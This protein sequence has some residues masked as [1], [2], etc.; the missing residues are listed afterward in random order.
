[1]SEIAGEPAHWD[2]RATAHI[3]LLLSEVAVRGH[4]T[5]VRIKERYGLAWVLKGPLCLLC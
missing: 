1:M 3:W 2:P 5:E 4:I